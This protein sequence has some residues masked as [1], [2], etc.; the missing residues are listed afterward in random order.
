MC[1]RD[2]C[3]TTLRD[4]NQSDAHP[5]QK[6]ILS[7][8]AKEEGFLRMRKEPAVGNAGG[9]HQPLERGEAGAEGGEEGVGGQQAHGGQ[10]LAPGACG[11]KQ[12]LVNFFYLFCCYLPFFLPF[13]LT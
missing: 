3:K 6:I 8:C 13:I 1:N 12:I 7:T 4:Q 5:G 10:A 9:L 11:T 2:I